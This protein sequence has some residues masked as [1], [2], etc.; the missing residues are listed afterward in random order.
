MAAAYS[1]L[2]IGIDPSTLMLARA[3]LQAGGHLLTVA[4]TVAEAG[5]HLTNPGLDVVYLQPREPSQ[6]ME[7]LQQVLAAR[8]ELAVVLVCAQPSASFVLQAWRAGAAGVLELP[9]GPESWES[10]LQRAVR[11]VRPKLPESAGGQEACLRYRDDSGKECRLAVVPPKLTIGRNTTNDLVLTQTSSSR[12]HA[13][14]LVQEGEYILRDLGSRHGT[15]VNGERVE[16]TSLKSGDR[17]QFGGVQGRSLTFDEGDLLQ[18]LLGRSES[19]SASGLPIRGFREMGSLLST[20][21]ALSSIRLLDDLLALVVDTAIALTHAERGFIMLKEADNTL[22]FRCARNRH[23]QNLAGSTFQTSRR[24]PEEAFHGGQ[25]IVINDLD[26]GDYLEDHQATI[27][28]GLRSLICVPLKHLPYRAGGSSSGAGQIETIGVLYVD[29]QSVAAGLSSTQADILETLAAEAAM[30]IYNARLYKDFQEKRRMEEELAIAQEIQQALLPAPNR[31]LPFVSAATHHLPCH[32]VG[33]DYFD[34]FEMNGGGFGFALGDVAGKG[35]PAALLASVIQ[36]MFA[37]TTLLDLPIADMLSNV[38]RNL[39]KR[40]TG[41]RFVTFFFGVLDAEGNCSYTNAGHNP[42]YVVG[43]DGSLRQLTEGGMVLGLFAAAQYESR[44]IRLEPGD[45][46]VLF[47]DGV[48][49]ALNT[50]GEEFGEDR[51]RTLLQENSRAF[52]TEILQRLRESVSA[53]SAKAPQH[54]DITMMILGYREPGTTGS[55]AS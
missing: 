12:L 10:S 43:S 11:R 4:A 22:S 14:I 21:R 29:S 45:H 39:V 35:M 17:I 54:D 30:A 55:A 1:I 44:T 46:L 36:G 5:E 50:A 20:F 37:A 52:A 32:Q 41:N 34:Y 27:R 31:V 13:E 2:L 15:Y 40:G 33:G 9:L 7:E 47:T 26:L 49:E 38:N 53:F 23:K 18:S 16:Q 28:L 6:A 19:S 24:V 3:S 48:I 51:L 25:R 8:S 42:P